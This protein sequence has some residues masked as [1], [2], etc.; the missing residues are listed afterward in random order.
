MR[1]GTEKGSVAEEAESERGFSVLTSPSECYLRAART[2]WDWAWENTRK[3]ECFVEGVGG[4]A[5]Y[6]LMKLY[7]LSGT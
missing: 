7:N 4:S 1:T 5:C 2:A 6:S 3:M